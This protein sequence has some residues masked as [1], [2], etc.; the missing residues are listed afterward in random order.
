MT[1]SKTKP[2][3]YFPNQNELPKNIF[4]FT[5]GDPTGI[6]P[7]IFEK[8]L[9]NTLSLIQKTQETV[10][11]YFS[12]DINEH[13]QKIKSICQEKEIFFTKYEIQTREKFF[14]E[15]KFSSICTTGV[16]FCDITKW[17]SAMQEKKNFFRKM[18]KM[19]S[20]DEKRTRKFSSSPI[21]KELISG[22]PNQSSGSFA[23]HSLQIACDFAMR[24]GCNGMLTAPLSK[25]WV[26]RSGQK[27]FCGHTG[28]LSRYFQKPTMMLMHGR[29]WSV[30]PLTEHIPLRKVPSRLK[31]KIRNPSLF[32]LLKKVKNLPEYGFPWAL[33]ALN[34]HAGENGLIGR[35]E[36]DFLRNW[37]EQLNQEGLFVEGPISA[38]ALFVERNLK[39]YRLILS[40]YHDQGLIPFKSLQ[41]KDGVNCTIGLPFLRTSPDHGPSFDIAGK[42]QADS[43]S[44]EQAFHLLLQEM[45]I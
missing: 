21:P 6:S 2:A 9:Q 27:N 14:L 26:I 34:P 29:D 10:L 38:D 11:I 42:N 41:G 3:S 8:M 33:C 7:E 36:K 44:M 24:Y 43:T 45:K 37:V 35:E 16:L 22:N 15:L 28:Y 30:I 13:S 25:E 40:C 32:H 18:Y 19:Q 20:K 23:F 12:T 17:A 4:L 31:Q 5:G 1:S 39:K